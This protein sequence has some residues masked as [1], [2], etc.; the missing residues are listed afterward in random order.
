MGSSRELE[1]EIDALEKK[2]KELSGNLDAMV[3]HFGEAM[4]PSV[5]SW[6]RNE[7]K[8][9]IEENALQVNLAGKAALQGLKTD[10]KDLVGDLPNVCRRAVEKQSTWPHR[11][12]LSNRSYREPPARGLDFFEESFRRAINPLGAVLDKHHLLLD[13]DKGSV[14]RWERIGGTGF[15]YAFHPGFTK[16]SF[17]DLERYEEVLKDFSGQAVRLGKLRT[18]LEQARARELWE[19][20]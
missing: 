17:P 12:D 7:V 6:M 8:R 14:R 16:T 13:G 3:V 9:A 18:A 11:A 19:D 10:L 1:A 20:V 5:E 4:V 2:L 15:R